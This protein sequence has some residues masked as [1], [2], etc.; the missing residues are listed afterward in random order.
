LAPIARA[1]KHKRV[2]STPVAP[3][4][5]SSWQ[6]RGW[7]L[8]SCVLMATDHDV[9]WQLK[10]VLVALGAIAVCVVFFENWKKTRGATQRSAR[11]AE[12]EPSM[13]KSFLEIMLTRPVGFDFERRSV[14][15]L[16]T[17]LRSKGCVLENVAREVP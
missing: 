7:I 13:F 17:E 8:S 10:T 4:R 12:M 14:G 1:S 11:I 15:D 6:G 2:Y 9:P 5:S 16:D 3:V